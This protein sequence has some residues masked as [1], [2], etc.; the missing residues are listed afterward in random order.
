MLYECGNLFIEEPFCRSIAFNNCCKAV[1][2]WNAQGTQ[3]VL[4]SI[5]HICAVTE[6]KG[7]RA[8]CLRLQRNAC[9]RKPVLVCPY[10]SCI[11]PLTS[12]DLH[13][14]KTLET[15]IK[16]TLLSCLLV[17][18][19]QPCHYSDQIIVSATMQAFKQVVGEDEMEIIYK[20]TFT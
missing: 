4:V 20:A 11:S 7:R 3:Q 9:R 16:H 19:S 13:F 12:Y 8:A 15:F 10:L 17:A 18:A 6:E 14:F 5:F 2:Y 1:L